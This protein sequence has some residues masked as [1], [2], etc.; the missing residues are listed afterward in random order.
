MA[1]NP[2]P[3]D[4]EK[5]NRGQDTLNS[6]AAAPGS[7]RRSIKPR[8]DQGLKQQS[9]LKRVTTDKEGFKERSKPLASRD[10]NRK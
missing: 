5:E 1:N 8:L 9:R 3:V 4:L 2:V 7:W 6:T 10:T